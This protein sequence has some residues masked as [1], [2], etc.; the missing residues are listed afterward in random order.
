MSAPTADDAMRF[1]ADAVLYQ[2]VDLTGPWQGWRVRGRDLVAP[3]GQRVSTQRLEG[4]LWRDA[5][6]LR[7]AG[8]TSRKKA[9]G[10]RRKAQP[11]KVVVVQL[12][13]YL[14][15]RAAAAA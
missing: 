15:G 12:G 14:E 6:E 13:E 1:M 11:V 4:L 2:R 5:M 10:E 7:L 3:D 8:Y 9:E